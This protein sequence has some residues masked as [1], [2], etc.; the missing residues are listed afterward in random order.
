MAKLITWFS[1]TQVVSDVSEDHRCAEQKATGQAGPG[2]ES[3]VK[4]GGA[5]PILPDHIP[6]NSRTTKAHE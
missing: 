3:L 6:T 1:S 5:F 2:Y 4:N